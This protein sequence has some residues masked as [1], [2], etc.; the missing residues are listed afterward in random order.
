MSDSYKEN[1]LILLSSVITRLLSSAG[2]CL[3][4][5]K[6]LLN[7]YP[8]TVSYFENVIIPPF[9]ETGG[10]LQ[11][12]LSF[13]EKKIKGCDILTSLKLWWLPAT[14]RDTVVPLNRS[15]PEP[16]QYIYNACYSTSLGRAKYIS[17]QPTGTTFS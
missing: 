15:T 4:L 9:L 17:D 10:N 11:K 6:L 14:V 5:D 12:A 7:T 2:F 1:L 3:L 8:T 13:R 16:P